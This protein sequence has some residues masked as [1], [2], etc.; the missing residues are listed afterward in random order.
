M[1][2]SMFYKIVRPIVSFLFKIFFTP[3]I[4]G[5]ENIPTSG[6]IVLA[7]NHTSNLD[8][9]LLLSS[10]KRAIHFLAKKELWNGPKKII[11]ANLGL[12]P[13]DR[14][15]H[16]PDALK[17]ANEYL[18]SGLLVLVFPEGTTEKGR[19]LLEF[20]RGAVKMASETSS[21]ITPFVITGKYKLF[22]RSLKI[23]FLK[24]ISVTND[25]D[26]ETDNLRNIIKKGLE[27]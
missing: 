17:K 27:D 12:I 22:S 9:L 20:K 6:K 7:G 21:K 2:D 4:E 24:P 23:K 3:K 19:G 13:V 25:I 5:K 1:K 15:K 10:T 11:F 26:K 8:C 14:T 18:K 16:N